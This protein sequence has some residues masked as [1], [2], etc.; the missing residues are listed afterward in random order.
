MIDWKCP[1]GCTG[2]ASYGGECPD[3]LGDG[4]PCPNGIID[5]DGKTNK[6]T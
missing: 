5:D 1:E 2:L 6:N 4:E 3:D